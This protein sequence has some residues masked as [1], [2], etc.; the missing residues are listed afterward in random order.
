MKNLLEKLDKVSN[1]TF[2]AAI[3]IDSKGQPLGK[4]LVRY[5]TGSGGYSNETGVLLNHK[6]I[7]LDFNKSMKGDWY[8][9]ASLY[10]LLAEVGC[11]VLDHSKREFYYGA[12]SDAKK[13]TMRNVNSMS[14]CTDFK[15]I[16]KGNTIFTINWI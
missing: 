5:T 16:K 14:T 2:D 15:Y 7:H 11:K 3:I 10:H 9:K 1:Q 8:E 13:D 4:V 12:I 6:R